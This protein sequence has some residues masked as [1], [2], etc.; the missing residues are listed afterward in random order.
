MI[1]A[2]TRWWRHQPILMRD[3]D[4]DGPVD[5][6]SFRARERLQVHIDRTEADCGSSARAGVQLPKKRRHG[7]R[8][9]A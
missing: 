8:R 9:A 2:I 7:L 6:W 4:L 1:A 5:V 3:L